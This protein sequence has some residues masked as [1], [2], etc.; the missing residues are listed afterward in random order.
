MDVYEYRYILAIILLVIVDCIVEITKE[1]ERSRERVEFGAK[2]SSTTTTSTT[3]TV[4][5][6]KAVHYEKPFHVS[7]RDVPLPKI[8]H[9]DDVIIKV[10]TSGRF[11]VRTCVL[12]TF[13]FIETNEESEWEHVFS[14]DIHSLS[15]ARLID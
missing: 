13:S 8:E 7:V 15:L 10:T 3:N 1:R 12:H 14:P 9:P 4:H 11:V 6:M 5:S 2:M